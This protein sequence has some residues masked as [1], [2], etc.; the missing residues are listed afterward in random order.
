MTTSK[1]LNV[2]FDLFSQVGFD[3]SIITNPGES[4]G[5][6]WTVLPYL[7]SGVSSNHRIFSG[8]KKGGGGLR[9]MFAVFGIDFKLA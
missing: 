8:I 4:Y 7:I 2:T 5:W 3:K 6:K 1:I 9:L